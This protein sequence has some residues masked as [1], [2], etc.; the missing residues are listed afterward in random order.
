MILVIDKISLALT[1]KRPFYNFGGV[2]SNFCKGKNLGSESC[3]GW[4][5]G[6]RACDLGNNKFW[7][8]VVSALSFFLTH[9]L[10][11]FAKVGLRQ[12][13]RFLFSFLIFAWNMSASHF[14]EHKQNILF[15]SCINEDVILLTHFILK[16][17]GPSGF[18]LES[19]C[20][21]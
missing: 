20:Y 11:S 9:F 5:L 10:L 16:N 3:D 12:V 15:F 4:Y 14:N 19:D 18:S 1:I 2:D 13:S 6:T 8:I 17:L 21:K 7:L